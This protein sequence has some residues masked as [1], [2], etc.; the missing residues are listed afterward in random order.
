[1]DFQS[2]SS[3]S[4]RKKIV[5]TGGSGLVGNELIKQLITQNNDIIALYNKNPINNIKAD[6]LTQYQCDILDVDY[7]E[8]IMQGVDEVYHC[9]AIVSFNPK[10]T[11][12][13][14]RVNVEGTANVVNAAFTTGV[15]KLV[16]VSSVAALGKT[17]N[18]DFITEKMNWIEDDSKSNYSKSKFFGEMEVWRANAEGLNVV[19]VNPSIILGG[20][21]WKYGSMKIFKSVY[22]KF[23]WY[24]EGV[25]GFVDVRD[26]CSIMIQLMN[27]PI[28]GERFIVSAENKSYKEVFEL[29]A[30]T[31]KVPRPSKK[32]TP[33]IG[34]IVWRLEAIKSF[35]TNK[36]PLVTKETAKTALTISNY[37]N[38]KLTKQFPEFS[39][40]KME[41][42]IA[43]SC[44]ELKK[45]YQLS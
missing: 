44:N 16:H 38:S 28:S 10:K 43:H 12:E 40:R 33:L 45:K 17:G 24:S 23:P 11:T 34:A 35:F 2:Q 4:P 6:N 8:E 9:A 20:T 22:E 15:K 19:I 27:S 39:Y 41:D 31:F 32:V 29:I 37:D 7:L 13:L 42:T 36:A 18:N 5:I 25:N 21:D 30:D 14:F 26:L 1:M 3:I